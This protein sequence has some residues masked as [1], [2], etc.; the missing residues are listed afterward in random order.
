M[1]RDPLPVAARDINALMTL[2]PTHSVGQYPLTMACMVKGVG[3]PDSIWVDLSAPVLSYQEL[4]RAV[5][6]QE[7]IPAGCELK[8]LLSPAEALRDGFR[9]VRLGL[10]SVSGAGD[11]FDG[12]YYIRGMTHKYGHG[13]S[14]GSSAT[15]DG[16]LRY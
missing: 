16:R 7:L 8:P 11:R 1:F 15:W 5:Y 9:L 13:S 6:P 12:K 2:G 14:V 3:G 10:V 4:W